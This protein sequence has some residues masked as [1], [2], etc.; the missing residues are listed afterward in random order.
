MRSAGVLELHLVCVAPQVD[1]YNS[2]TF[3]ASLPQDGFAVR[4]WGIAQES[5][6]SGNQPRKPSGESVQQVV[7][8][9]QTEV[10]RAFC[11]DVVL[12]FHESWGAAQASPRR[13]GSSGG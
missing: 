13:I 5:E 1:G 12:G 10:N 3:G 9:S 2:A 11:A 6:L 4:T 7:S 8:Q